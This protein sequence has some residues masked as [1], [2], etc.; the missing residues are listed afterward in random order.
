MAKGIVAKGCGTITIKNNV[1]RNLDTAVEL[2]ECENINLDNNFVFNDEEI[3][4]FI[5]NLYTKFAE[6][7]QFP[8]TIPFELVKDLLVSKSKQKESNLFNWLKK[9]GFNASWV[10]STIL[11]MVPSFF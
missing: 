7:D 9:E 6:N 4:N 5:D 1:F 11:S 8:K 10:I 2:N 3:K